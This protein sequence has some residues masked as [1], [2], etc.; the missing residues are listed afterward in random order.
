MGPVLRIGLTGGIGAGKSTVGR[1]LTELGAVLIDADVLAREA[2]A[3][4]TD[5]LAEVRDAFG[6]A[7]IGTE[8]ALD[9]EA[10]GRVVFADEERRRGLEAIIHPRVAERRAELVAQAPGDAIVVEDIPL[11][12]ENDLAAGFP[13][14]IVVH[15]D[16][17]ERVRRLTAS[18][19]MSPADA[20]ERTRAQATDEQRRAAADVWLDN[21]GPP[22]RV[23]AEVDRLWTERL[24]PYE[25]NLR[26]GERAP[27]LPH[28]V[29]AD[30][31][32][33]WARQA[34]RLIGRVR[35]VAGDRARRIDHIGSTSVPGLA[36]KDVL[37]LQVVVADLATAGQVAVDLAAAGLVRREGHWSDN[38]PAGEVWDK[39][40]VQNA[41][42]A[43][44]VNCH[45]R[46]YGS[47]AWREVLLLRDY[48]RAHPIAVEEYARLKGNLAA[49][50]HESIDA[51]AD[52]KTPWI[53]ATLARAARSVDPPR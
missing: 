51:Y 3:P 38:G 4:G 12:V 30:P 11:L 46:P 47:P 34:E 17:S 33:T 18:R 9:R 6:D 23:R 41:D 27:R 19:G 40:M 21:S 39:A 31:D 49:A 44:A 26:A 29:L 50:P 22:G 37:D 2:V 45:V 13:L 20:R 36:A 14:V 52:A 48:L 10:L 32:P 15:A 24:V 35:A 53:R 16:E 5:G 43:R 42:P 1:R 8:G 25:A 7:V 28:A